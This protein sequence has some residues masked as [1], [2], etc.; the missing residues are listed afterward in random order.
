MDRWQWKPSRTGYSKEFLRINEDI[1]RPTPPY[2]Y[3]RE[4]IKNHDNSKILVQALRQYGNALVYFSII[5]SDTKSFNG[6]YSAYLRITGNSSPT[7]MS[8]GY[9]F[10]GDKTDHLFQVASQVDRMVRVITVRHISTRGV[11]S[12]TKYMCINTRRIR[13]STWEL[14]WSK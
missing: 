6:I 5:D 1:E 4:K 9:E 14:S 10:S 7:V 11:L 13:Y 12:R 3:I 2:Q 8:T